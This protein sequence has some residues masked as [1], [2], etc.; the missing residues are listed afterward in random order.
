MRLLF[1]YHYDI[2]LK[3]VWNLLTLAFEY[4]FF[5]V[6]HSFVDVNCECLRFLYYLLAPTFVAVLLVD[7]SLTFASLAWLLHLHLH[8]THI[9]HYFDHSLSIALVASFCLATF[10]TATLAFITVDVPLDGNFFNDSVVQFLQSYREINFVLRALHTIVTSS[11]VTFDFI[12]ALLI[13]DL[14]L[15][16]VGQH[17]VSP[18]N[19]CELL[20]SVLVARVFVRVV[21]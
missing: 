8:E 16:I 6:H 18:V 20:C 15:D 1:E 12:F 5:F 4:N 3:H 21:L 2:A 13:I 10:S 17:L 19:L 9:L 14:T 11:L 7:S